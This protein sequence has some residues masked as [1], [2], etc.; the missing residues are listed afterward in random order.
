[1]GLTWNKTF[2]LVIAVFLVG[3]V[4]VSLLLARALYLAPPLT[5]VSLPFYLTLPFA[6]AI[7]TLILCARARPSGSW[8]SR[9][10]LPVCIVVV[11]GSY[12][13]LVPLLFHPTFYS[14]VECHSATRSG[15]HVQH[16]CTCRLESV[17][18][19]VQVECSLDGFALSPILPVTERGKWQAIP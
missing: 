12:W 4:V 14:A 17:S 5:N 19:R 1:M 18:G 10:L 2:V 6:L 7:L 9:V 15:L 8:I 3:N 16:L 13:A 11:F